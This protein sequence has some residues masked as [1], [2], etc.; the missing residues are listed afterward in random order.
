MRLAG[1]VG[2]GGAAALA[3]AALLAL[4]GAAPA[5]AVA[6]GAGSVT[7]LGAFAAADVQQATEETAKKQKLDSCDCSNCVGL[8]YR[9]DTR[10]GWKG[11]A[12]SP[13]EAVAANDTQCQQEGDRATWV[14]QNSDVLTYDRFCK[15]TCKPL[16]PKRIQPKV[17]C[18]VLSVWER[19]L[20]AQT[21]SGNGRAFIFKANPMTNTDALPPLPPEES[22]DGGSLDSVALLRQAFQQFP[23]SKGATAAAP[24]PV[25][26]GK[27]CAKCN[28]NAAVP[29]VGAVPPA[30]P[31]PTVPPTMPPP[32]PVPPPPPLPPPPPPPPPLMQVVPP[33]PV[34][35]L[36]M[37]LLPQELPTPEPLFTA[38]YQ[39]TM[40]PPASP[41][42]EDPAAGG[43]P[44]MMGPPPPGPAA[45]RWGWPEGVPMPGQYP[46]PGMQPMPGSGPMPGPYG[47]MPQPGPYGALPGPAGAMAPGAVSFAS[48]ASA[49]PQSWPPPPLGFAGQQ[50][51]PPWAAFE[52]VPGAAV[53]AYGYGWPAGYEAGVG[54]PATVAGDYE[55]GAAAQGWPAAALLQVQ[56]ETLE[57]AGCDCRATCSHESPREEALLEAER[58]AEMQ[59]RSQ[60]RALRGQ[61]GWTAAEEQ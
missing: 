9:G 31:W 32:P 21:A 34:F 16:L 7:A 14:V 44:A 39:P 6:V 15:F 24:A 3:S 57:G 50:A 36:E 35:P 55:L 45:N 20:E 59:A 22:D 58:N 18:G 12:C 23:A 40:P 25:S 10:P 49:V 2:R 56:A 29:V 61:R 11:F 5:A 51:P 43:Q 41:V 27:K 4:L 46:F 26:A 1:R 13:V 30:P 19:R 33:L 17:P 8:L 42:I 47:A 53:P 28:C 38:T 48:I 52:S 37:P 60:R 54:A